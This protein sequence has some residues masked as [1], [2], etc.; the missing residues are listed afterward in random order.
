ML[1]RALELFD[2]WQQNRHDLRPRF[3]EG[4]IPDG[5]LE[6]LD[7]EPT[8]DLSLDIAFPLLERRLS[9]IFV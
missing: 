1:Q 8:I 7:L 9:S 5:G 4:L 2:V 3:V 6:T